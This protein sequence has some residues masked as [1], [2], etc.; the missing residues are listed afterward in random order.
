MYI[1]KIDEGIWEKHT[2]SKQGEIYHY[3]LFLS[4]ICQQ[5][6]AK[7]PNYSKDDYSTNMGTLDFRK[8]SISVGPFN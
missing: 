4:K 6:K 8:V 2:F 5:R 3:H 7:K 1:Q